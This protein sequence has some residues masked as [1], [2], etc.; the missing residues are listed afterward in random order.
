[1]EPQEAENATSAEAT[2]DFTDTNVVEEKEIDHDTEQLKAKKGSALLNLPVKELVTIH[3][4]EE[5][6]DRLIRWVYRQGI[7]IAG[8]LFVLG[9]FGVKHQIDVAERARKAS[10]TVEKALPLV[11]N[12]AQITDSLTKR[13][14]EIDTQAGISSSE[15]ERLKGE[16][17]I[18][19][20][21]F[22]N[23]RSALNDLLTESAKKS[24]QLESTLRKYEQEGRALEQ[25]RI[26]FTENQLFS[27]IIQH[28]SETKQRALKCKDLLANNGF[29]RIE[30]NEL[31][32]QA[33]A[34]YRKQGFSERVQYFDEGISAKAREI[35]ELLQSVANFTIDIKAGEKHDSSFIIWIL[36]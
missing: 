3:I 31:S 18:L 16:I 2:L 5:A 12:F 30:L 25:K 29:L 35:A 9:Y 24:D 10:E 19:Q 4:V 21:E 13:L 22:K 32:T 14:A 23:S 8:V 34:V 17:S 28:S 6:K 1:M 11:S 26:Q 20:K 36:K 15:L 27:I 7:A 33:S